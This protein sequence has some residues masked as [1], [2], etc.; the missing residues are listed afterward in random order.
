MVR[1]LKDWFVYLRAALSVLVCAFFGLSASAAE[2]PVGEWVLAAHI[3]QQTTEWTLTVTKEGAS[4]N[5]RI[6]GPTRISAAVKDANGFH[7]HS[8]KSVFSSGKTRIRVLL[9]DRLPLHRRVS[10]LYVLPVEPKS[11]TQFGDGLIEIKRRDLHNKYQLICVAPTFAYHPW[12]ADHPSDPGI[13]QE[14]HFLKIVLP[15]VEQTYPAL[16][17]RKGRL[18]VGFSKS[19]WGAFS[20]LLRHPDRFAK[21]AAWDAPLM[22][23][24][25][26]WPRPVEVFGTQENF[27]KYEFSSLVGKR[28]RSFNRENRLILL[29]YGNFRDEHQAAHR[30]MN[31]LGV[32]HVYMDGPKRKHDWHSG[33]LQEAVALLNTDHT[34]STIAGLRVD[35]ILARMGA[36][37]EVA[38]SESQVA[39]YGRVFSSID[40]DG[41]GDL[42]RKE[43]VD[44][45]VYLTR[46]ARTGIFVASDR[47]MDNVVSKAEY[48]EN[49]FITDEARTI[50]QKMDSDKDNRVTDDEYINNSALNDKQLAATVFSSLDTD[51]NG[52]LTI[53]EF[54]RVW[55]HWARQ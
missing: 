2:G 31:A 1:S 29:G 47:N 21:A 9:P 37:G 33:W 14:T 38:P 53:P 15:F 20:L 7:V 39:S 5:A 41:D 24:L 48:F 16:T 17:E 4:L 35:K 12:Y 10:T 19:G 45:G 3:G 54:L 6:D 23:P 55:G 52:N 32:R 13:R 46:Q 34:S 22:M 30:M 49:R 42:S 50:F 18:L 8:V 51:N 27:Q 26:R 28:A 36:K 25:D 44:D 11:G 43:F 40:D